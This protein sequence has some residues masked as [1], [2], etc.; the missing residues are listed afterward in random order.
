MI[1]LS[2]KRFNRLVVRWP[3]GRVGHDVV[4]M[5]QCDCG[6]T[7]TVTSGNLRRVKSCGCFRRTH[8]N[9]LRHGHTV[10]RQTSAT[11]NTWMRML[12]RCHNPKNMGYRD[13]GGRGI[14]V[15]SRW[16][17]FDNFLAD[18]GVRPVGKFIERNDNNGNYEPNNCRWATRKEQRANRRDT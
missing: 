14:S 13:Y 18:M 4:W 2:N 10:N 5:C 9:R 8:R 15:C 6:N 3:V 17:K 12:D 16:L 11:Y 1:D 7:T